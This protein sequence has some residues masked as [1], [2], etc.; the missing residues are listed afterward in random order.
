[1]DTVSEYTLKRLEELRLHY[2][3]TAEDCKCEAQAC[4]AREV[5]YKSAAAKLKNTIDD[6][7]AKYQ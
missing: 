7:K 5:A 3:L 6:I 4:R 1:M 2:Q